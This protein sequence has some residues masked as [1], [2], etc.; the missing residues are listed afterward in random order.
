MPEMCLPPLEPISH[1]DDDYDD[2]LRTSL[3]LDANTNPSDV[4]SFSNKRA[5]STPVYS[6]PLPT[7]P[8]RVSSPGTN[9]NQV[10]RAEILQ[11]RPVS[12]PVSKPV[13]TLTTQPS[14]VKELPKGPKLRLFISAAGLRWPVK[15]KNGTGP[16]GVNRHKLI[17]A[18]VYLQEGPKV[19]SGHHFSAS[20]A[21]SAVTEGTGT[22]TAPVSGTATVTSATMSYDR[23]HAQQRSSDSS[24]DRDNDTVTEVAQ[25]KK[26]GSGKKG[27]LLGYT[28]KAQIVGRDVEFT[29]TFSFTYNASTS[30]VVNVEVY[31]LPNITRSSLSS[32]SVDIDGNSI[33]GPQP[34]LVGTASFALEDIYEDEKCGKVFPIT[35][36]PPPPPVPTEPETKR[37]AKRRQ[38][39][40]HANVGN[41]NVAVEHLPNGRKPHKYFIDIQCASMQ[42]SR[43]LGKAR[44]KTA[45]YT[46][47]GVGR[48][49][50]EESVDAKNEHGDEDDD[51]V[52]EDES[53]NIHESDGTSTSTGKQKSRDSMRKRRSKR[54]SKKKRKVSKGRKSKTEELD[55]EDTPW[56][57]LCRSKKVG[58]VK[59][60]KD[61]GSM[62]YNYFS[63]RPLLATPGELFKDP[64]ANDPAAAEANASGN[65]LLGKV[66]EEAQRRL[67]AQFFSM[68]SGIFT[69]VAPDRRLKLSIMD[70]G[71]LLADTVFTVDKLRSMQLGDKLEMTER[72][73]GRVVG[74][75]MLKFVEKADMPAYFCLSVS[76]PELAKE[77]K[78]EKK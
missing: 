78:K 24:G 1:S 48:E 10:E 44:V 45:Y 42:R 75:S 18:K 39:K 27:K 26:Q 59:K 63:S 36:L 54:D 57:L 67:D 38:R 47:H 29:K 50:E 46:I 25:K 23:Y 73:K 58:L 76:M 12:V 8:V 40:A 72:K 61:G 21:V 37:A 3:F 41:I 28:E 35:L 2:D 5:M 56:V 17:Y 6:L 4:V 51:D 30:P 34:S 53:E 14:L 69:L 32:T 70:S 9:I 15:V 7:S 11:K 60:K 49:E 33:G 68:P 22:G 64:A 55:D 77:A 52:Q 43:A 13:S 65:K 66:K 31:G 16:G 62:E 71:E 19:H 20:S 74:H